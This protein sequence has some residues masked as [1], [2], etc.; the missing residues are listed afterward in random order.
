MNNL[1]N[2]SAE[3]AELFDRY[4]EICESNDMDA[5]SAWWDTME[6]IDGEFHKRAAETA[7]Y[8]KQ[9]RAEAKMIE[10]EI[11][12]LTERMKSRIARADG[13]TKYLMDAMAAMSLDKIED[14]RVKLTIRTN[15][16]SVQLADKEEFLRWAQMSGRTELLKY[17]APTVS[18]TAVKEAVKSGEDLPGAS[19]VRTKRLEVK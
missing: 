12:V 1:Y 8:I 11:D 16:E 19:V 5:I 4:D 3:F 15:P 18:L 7:L 10:N 17:A 2:I 6:G 14:P 9:I 13:L